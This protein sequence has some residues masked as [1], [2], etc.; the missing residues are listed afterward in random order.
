MAKTQVRT[1]QIQDLNLQIEDLKEFGV[2]DAGGINITVTAGRV[3]D[4]TTITNKNSQAL[5]LTDDATNFVEITAAGV[6]SANTS[7]FTSGRIPLAEVV[8]ASADITSITDKRT[9]VSVGSAGDS[10]GT[11]F[12]GSHFLLMGA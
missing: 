12:A 2:V 6:A 11:R 7:A 9:W 3:R 5:A 8:T 10:G 1:G 4:D